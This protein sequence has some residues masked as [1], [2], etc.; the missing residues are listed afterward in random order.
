MVRNID[1]NERMR[2][3]DL[4]NRYISTYEDP[5]E[6]TRTDFFIAGW[7]ARDFE[8]NKYRK[9]LHGLGWSDEQIDMELED[10]EHK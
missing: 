8:I 6:A 4:L 1:H 10:G 3:E 9:F 5:N 2:I 7:L